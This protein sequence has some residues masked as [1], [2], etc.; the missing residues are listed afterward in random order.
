[1]EELIPL[2]S[3]ST[4]VGQ[5]FAFDEGACGASTISRG[6]D[7]LFTSNGDAG[8]SVTRS[9]WTSMQQAEVA[10]LPECFTVEEAYLI[11]LNCGSHS[12]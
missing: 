9:F 2:L 12:M 3:C 4:K 6:R 10:Y 11:S 7:A 1:M 8:G 5:T